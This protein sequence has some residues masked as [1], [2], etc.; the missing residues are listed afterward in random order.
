MASKIQLVSGYAPLLWCTD[1]ANPACRPEIAQ[2]RKNK[3]VT[4]KCYVDDSRFVGI[5]SSTRWFGVKVG[6]KT[7]FVHS[8]YVAK[9]KPNTPLCGGPGAAIWG[10]ANDA[11]KRVGQLD[12]TPDDHRLLAG[13]DWGP[14]EV[15]Y[16]EWSGDCYRFAFV[17]WAARGYHAVLAPTALR[18]GLQ[19]KL[20]K[21][22]PDMGALVFYTGVRN[23]EGED[24]GHAGVSVG[25]GMVVST[26]GY[27][28]YHA[29]IRMAPYNGI[30][31][32]YWGWTRLK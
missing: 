17:I 21:T 4:M 14:A 9:Q 30:Q 24:V 28:G 5:Y 27:D 19:Y 2:L 15:P 10:V 8:S 16:G 11:A 29:A 26:T 3:I 7:G 31:P 1:M 6:S 25:N 20:K 32:V 12:A 22:K 23:G 13:A 18:A